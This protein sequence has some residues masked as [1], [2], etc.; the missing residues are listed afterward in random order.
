[1][2]DDTLV[3]VARLPTGTGAQAVPEAIWLDTRALRLVVVPVSDG[4]TEPPATPVEDYL[5]ARPDRAE[6]VRTALVERFQGLPLPVTGARYK[7]LS[8]K[9]NVDAEELIRQITP[10][11]CH[12]ESGSGP[13]VGNEAW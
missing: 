5:A 12:P 11:N 9:K 3:H 6:A 1:M 8:R 10:E 4:D 13:P 2:S 7:L